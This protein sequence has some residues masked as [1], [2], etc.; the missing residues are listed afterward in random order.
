MPAELISVLQFFSKGGWMIIPV[1]LFFVW[2]NLWLMWV[3]KRYAQNAN[4]I[5]LELKIPHT[6][7]RTPKVMEQ[8]FGG[9]H[10]AHKPSINFKER[11][12]DGK[13][14]LYI[15]MEIAGIDG[16]I[17][18][19]IYT[20]GEF[21]RLIES[22]IYAQYKD[23]EITEVSDYMKNLPED[24]PNETHDLFGMELMFTKDDAYPIRTYK[25]FEE[26]STE[27][28][29]IDPIA[30]LMEILGELKPGEQVWLQYLIKPVGTEW[31]KKGQAL[32]NRL[33]GKKEAGK[34]S[35]NI[36]EEVFQFFYDMGGIIF[37]RI[38]TGTT[39]QKKEER[40][41]PET[42]MQHLPPGMKDV[43]AALE[44]SISKHGFEVVI[45]IVYLARRDVFDKSTMGA[46]FG[47]FKQFSTYNL[48]GFKPNGKVIPAINYVF[49]KTREYMRKR[50]LFVWART[51]EFKKIAAQ[52][53]MILNTEELATIYHVPSIVLEVPMLPRIAAKKSE[54]PPQLPVV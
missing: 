17:H 38:P 15:S 12:W 13:H 33:I 4:W 46:V 28:K 1:I 19:F 41:G 18:F 6:V 47:T 35:S 53:K 39:E 51:R 49:K 25:F 10:A 43:V 29:Y 37:G 50:R 48:N 45:R 2:K 44:D 40:Q 8:V 26:P 9:L 11:W 7:E 30:S 27:K 20:P 23:A 22:Q 14:Q 5:T 36:M 16:S 54:P 21:K 32:I 31:Q 3:Q 52:Q 34:E 24:V 42:L